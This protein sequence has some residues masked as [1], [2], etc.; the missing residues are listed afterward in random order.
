MRFFD[1]PVGPH[2][3]IADHDLNDGVVVRSADLRIGYHCCLP[4]LITAQQFS[5]PPVELRRQDPDLTRDCRHVHAGL[6][7]LLNRCGLELVRPETPQLSRRPVKAI[8]HRLDHSHQSKASRRPRHRSSHSEK[9]YVR[10]TLPSIRSAR[11]GLLAAYNS[12]MARA[13]EFDDYLREAGDIELEN[14]FNTVVGALITCLIETPNWVSSVYANRGELDL[15]DYASAGF[16]NVT[17]YGE[18]A[19]L[20][21]EFKNVAMYSRLCY[22][23]HVLEVLVDRNSDVTARLR[24]ADV[25]DW[26]AI[27]REPYP[28]KKRR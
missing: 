27:A 12:I 10:N 20:Q 1:M 28:P 17:P 25:A 21:R 14:R 8:G 7:G 9:S 26:D 13:Q 6:T 22:G 15:G 4:R 11:W 23:G 19:L 5:V 24:V 2:D 16:G 18:Y 3:D